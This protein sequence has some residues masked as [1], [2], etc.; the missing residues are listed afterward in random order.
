MLPEPHLVCLI[1][2]SQTICLKI[3]HNFLC[4]FQTAHSD[5]GSKRT[6]VQNVPVRR[7]VPGEICFGLQQSLIRVSS[8]F[9]HREE[10]V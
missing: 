2:R 4:S 7:H 5:S 8:P 9:F 6:S 10:T 1:K 3:Q